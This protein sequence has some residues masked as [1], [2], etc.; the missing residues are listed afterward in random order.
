MGT[1]N[2][3]CVSSRGSSPEKAPALVNTVPGPGQEEVV[4]REE[5]GQ[6]QALQDLVSS[7]KFGNETVSHQISMN[8]RRMEDYCPCPPLPLDIK[9]FK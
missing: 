9:G 5:A 4:A 7:G 1:N 6:H 3:N 2:T 8:L